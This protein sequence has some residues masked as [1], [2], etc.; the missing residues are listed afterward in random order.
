[1]IRISCPRCQAALKLR[2]EQAGKRVLCPKCRTPLLVAVA[3]D[4]PPPVP[5]RRGTGWLWAVAVVLILGALG[6]AGWFIAFDPLALRRAPLAPPASVAQAQAAKPAAGPGP[7][8]PA[9]A[10]QPAAPTRSAAPAEA[11]PAQTPPPARRPGG[12]QRFA[13]LVGV[14]QYNSAELPDLKYT[15]ADVEELAKVLLAAGYP[16]ENVVLLTG[17]RAARDPQ[18]APT[19]AR[20][21]A[22]LDRL[23]RDRQPDDLVLVAFAGHGIERK[24]ARQFCFCPSGAVLAEASTLLSLNEVYEKLKACPAGYKLLLAD[25]CRNDPGTRSVTIPE[26]AN[27]PSVTRPQFA[28]PP[29]GVMAF[30]SCSASQFAYEPDDLRHGVFFHFLIEGLRGA[31][32]FDGDGEIIREEIEAYVKKRVRAYTAEKLKREQWPHL[33]GESNDQR[34]LVQLPGRP[35]PPSEPRPKLTRQ[36]LDSPLRINEDF[37]KAPRG[38]TPPGWNGRDL[39]GVYEK[40][41]IAHLRPTARSGVLPP[42]TLPDTPLAGGFFVECE[43]QLGSYGD[44]HELLVR[45]E[46]LGVGVPVTVTSAGTVTLADRPSQTIEGFNSDKI[47][48]LRLVRE[49]RNYRVS[50]NDVVVVDSPLHYTGN[51]ERVHLYLSAGKAYGDDAKLF[52][53]RVGLLAALGEADDAPPAARVGQVVLQEDFSRAAPG[54]A[55]DG[56][57][58]RDVVLVQRGAA[59]RAGLEA[60]AEKGEHFITLPRLSL[61][62]DF[63]AE[64]EFELGGYGDQ[65]DLVLRLEGKGGALPLRVGSGGQVTLADRPERQVSGFNCERVNRV[66]LVREGGRYVVSVNDVEVP[67][68]AFPLAGFAAFT[69]V[70]VGLTAGKAYG[71]TMKVYGVRLGT[72]GSATAGGPQVA[73]AGKGL[74]EDFRTAQLGGLPNGW[75]P[76][77]PTLGVQKGD[78]RHYLA[79]TDPA[80][81]GGLVALPP[82]ALPGDF[83]V[84]CEFDLPDRETSFVVRLEGRPR[85]VL[86]LGVQGDGKVTLQGRT[87]DAEKLL[88]RPG[89]VNRLRLER[90]ADAYLVHLNDVRLGQLPAQAAAEAFELLRLGLGLKAPENP[91]PKVYAVRVEPGE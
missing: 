43:F 56:W 80:R 29:G 15:E 24:A 10:E 71:P 5:L 77:A 21:R 66:R 64:C 81:G 3:Q 88:A 79:V 50:V 7:A 6:G 87:V 84:E 34:P 58:G 27:V 23:L 76:A 20:V 12:G 18:A 46:G 68:L 59:A 37:K 54:R 82:V 45:L 75:T 14:R 1:M 52:A 2:P 32:D 86:V 78:D 31:A 38:K 90:N 51:F 39:W 69:R 60:N 73:A 85:A 65:H 30:Y 44:Q 19:A 49:G 26:E 47:N 63:F 67:G 35:V 4:S 13:L 62:G 33:L 48:R 11:P 83:V 55:P 9:A 16:A 57:D 61:P 28:A 53:V 22:E 91:S 17:A 74:R 72:L 36:Q 89:R 25:A 41:G 40:D 70:Q 8:A 42:L